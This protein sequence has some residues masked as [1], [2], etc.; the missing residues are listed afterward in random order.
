MNSLDFT[1]EQSPWEKFLMTKTMGD[2]IPAAQVLTLLEGEEEQALEDALLDLETGYMEL[3][4][5]GLPKGVA[6]AKRLC[7]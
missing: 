4:L 7:G 2:S 6:G 5:E 3:S 1:F